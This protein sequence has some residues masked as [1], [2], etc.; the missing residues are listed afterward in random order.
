LKGAGLESL[1][2]SGLSGLKSCLYLSTFI[3]RRVGI[4]GVRVPADEGIFLFFK[5]P[6]RLW[7]PVHS[8]GQWIPEF[9]TSA[10]WPGREV[11]TRV[12]LVPGLRMSGSIS[13]LPLYAFVSWSGKN[14]LI[15]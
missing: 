11:T 9:I 14:L 5:S 3:R 13:L 7:G 6:Y 10:K 4:S 8:P 15:P 1:P 12:H 2:G